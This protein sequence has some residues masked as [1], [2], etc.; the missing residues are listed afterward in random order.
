MDCIAI[1]LSWKKECLIAMIRLIAYY[2]TLYVTLMSSVHAHAQQ[3]IK[4]DRLLEYENIGD[5]YCNAPF[6]AIGIKSRES[7]EVYL[8]ADG[9]LSVRYFSPRLDFFFNLVED[10]ASCRTG[11]DTSTSPEKRV[12]YIFA[13]FFNYL[14]CSAPELRCGNSPVREIAQVK[15]RGDWKTPSG[16]G[17]IR[18]GVVFSPNLIDKW[19]KVLDQQNVPHENI[20]DYYENAQVEEL[21]ALARFH[22]KI[23]TDGYAILRQADVATS[24]DTFTRWERPADCSIS[25]EAH[26]SHLIFLVRVTTSDDGVV[27]DDARL[28]M[29][30]FFTKKIFASMWSPMNDEETNIRITIGE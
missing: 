22:G 20:D 23:S 14:D 21:G 16:V 19:N 8:A 6:G 9:N 30:P 24:S 1:D 3:I 2:T 29:N 15:V 28:N 13:Q 12:G 7:R 26:C 5:F 25:E 11:F 4:N 18:K 27:R 17:S 10:T